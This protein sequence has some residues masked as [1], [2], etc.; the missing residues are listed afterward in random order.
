VA[1]ES[2]DR[3]RAYAALR[4]GNGVRCEYASF[5]LQ[6]LDGSTV[7]I[8]AGEIDVATAPALR[9]A[10][11]VA[12]EVSGNV[13]VDLNAVTFLDS[14]GIGA[15]MGGFKNVPANGSMCLVGAN[16][17]VAKVLRQTGLD[18]VIPVHPNLD[19][20]RGH[21]DDSATVPRRRHR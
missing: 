13:V 15:L 9:E 1:T 4:A 10:L 5:A 8:A 12:V 6:G 7:V 11:L 3:S 21:N 18:Q 16:G 17:M 20:L 19:A 14:T 2:D